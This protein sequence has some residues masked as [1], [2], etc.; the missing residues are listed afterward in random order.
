MKSI[1]AAVVRPIII[2]SIF[3]V[4]VLLGDLI[5]LSIN[6]YLYVQAAFVQI[7]LLGFALVFVFGHY[8]VVAQRIFEQGTELNSYIESLKKKEVAKPNILF[9]KETVASIDELNAK[10]KTTLDTFHNAL[11]ELDIHGST[12]IRLQNATTYNRTIENIDKKIST[13]L[14]LLK[15]NSDLKISS[16]NVWDYAHRAIKDQNARIKEQKKHED[17]MLDFLTKISSGDYRLRLFSNQEIAKRLNAFLNTNENLLSEITKAA[18]NHF[19][20]KLISNHAGQNDFVASFNR[21]IDTN[22]NNIAQIKNNLEEVQAKEKQRMQEGSSSKTIARTP[23]K[24]KIATKF[25]EIDFTGK[26]FGK[27]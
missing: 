3:V 15:E 12:K 20:T 1:K 22:N 25:Q 26:G 27:Y 16:T 14:S 19:T 24:P 18:E 11:N 10:N 17:D 9:F 8:I 5:V 2:F 6:P 21:G 7:F 23:A 4:L 13:T